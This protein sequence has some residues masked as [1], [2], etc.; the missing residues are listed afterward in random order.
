VSEFG[1]SWT[2]DGRYFVYAASL[3]NGRQSIFAIPE[4]QKLFRKS[5]PQAIEL[6]SGP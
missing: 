1:G 4:N 3:P 6:T 2:S 5:G